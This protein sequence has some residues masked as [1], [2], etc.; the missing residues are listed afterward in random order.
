MTSTILDMVSI[1]TG[2]KARDA[3]LVPVMGDTAGSVIMGG[4]SFLYGQPSYNRQDSRVASF[5]N[6]RRAIIEAIDFVTGLLETT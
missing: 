4:Q 3:Y 2:N 6:E 1:D 5:G